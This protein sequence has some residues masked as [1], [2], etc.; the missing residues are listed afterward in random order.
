MNAIILVCE[1]I[2]PTVAGSAGP[3]PTP[4]RRAACGANAT[5]AS[6][7]VARSRLLAVTRSPELVEIAPSS[8]DGAASSADVDNTLVGVVEVVRVALAARQQLAQFLSCARHRRLLRLR[9]TSRRQLQ[10]KAVVDFAQ[11]PPP[12]MPPAKLLFQAPEK[13]SRA[14]VGLQLV[15]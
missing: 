15:L 5:K 1:I 8:P 12:L 3:V 11:T 10:Y 13:Y 4:A 9:R 14:S 6:G 2:G 7:P